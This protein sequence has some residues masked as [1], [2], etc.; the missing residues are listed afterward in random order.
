MDVN[1][2]RLAWGAGIVV[3]ALILLAWWMGWFGVGSTTTQTAAPAL[4]PAVTSPTASAAPAGTACSV[5]P[6][7]L[8]VPAGAA[9]AAS[10]TLAGSAAD[11]TAAWII[12]GLIFRC[13]ETGSFS[14]DI[15]TPPQIGVTRTAALQMS[16]TGVT[17]WPESEAT[18]NKPT[19]WRLTSA[20]TI[21]VKDPLNSD[22]GKNILTISWQTDFS[23]IVAY[24]MAYTI[25]LNQK[26]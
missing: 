6:D 22:A 15:P 3:V 7:V 23:R 24:E 2:K 16:I 12:S 13:A 19:A 10:S 26:Q 18:E 20:P 25:Y 4:P 5:P 1:G 8:P 11:G 21:G 17:F 14:V 9:E